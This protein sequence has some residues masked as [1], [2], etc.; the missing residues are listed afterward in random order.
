MELLEK[1]DNT[2]SSLTFFLLFDL[3]LLRL[4]LLPLSPPLPL[5]LALLFLQSNSLPRPAL[6]PPTLSS[7]LFLRFN[8]LPRPSLSSL[9]YPLVDRE[10]VRWGWLF[11]LFLVTRQNVLFIQPLYFIGPPKFLAQKKYMVQWCVITLQ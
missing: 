4:R 9:L 5:S 10:F 8:S 1:E 11:T 7:L 6:S 3:V 2:S